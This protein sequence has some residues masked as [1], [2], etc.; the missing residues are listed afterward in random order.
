M[1]TLLSVLW[2]H[3]RLH[4]RLALLLAL[5]LVA[6]AAVWVAEPLYSGYAVDELLKIATGEPV[7]FARLFGWWAVLLVVIS[8]VE[9]LRKYVEWKFSMMLELEGLERSYAHAMRLNMHFHTT[10]RS[11]ETM[12]II[13]DGAENASQLA[14]NMIDLLPSFLAGGTFLIIGAMIEWRLAL[15]LLVM[16]A[17][18]VLIMVGGTMRTAKL[19]DKINWL[20]TLPS[21]RAMDAFANVTSVKSGSQEER[22]L[23]YMHNLHTDLLRKQLKIN[24]LWAILEGFHFFIITRVLLIIIS[25]LLLVRGEITLGELYFFQASFFRVLTPFEMLAGI[26]PQWNK[27]VGKVRMAEKVLTLMPEPGMRS[28]GIVPGKMEGKIEFR[29]VSFSY[30]AQ[31]QTEDIRPVDEISHAPESEPEIP[32]ERDAPLH[33]KARPDEPT[34]EDQKPVDTLQ[35]ITLTIRSGEHI[36]LVGESGAGKSTIAMLLNRFYDVTDGAILIDGKD[37]RE[38]DV[39]WWRS[40]IGLVL[41]EN[42]MFN[43]TVLEN[44]RYARPTAT[45]GEVLQAAQ[46]ASADGFIAALPKGMLTEIGERGVKLSGGQRQRIAIARAILKQ[47]TIVILDEATSAL[48]SITERE[49]QQGIAELIAKRTAIIIAHRLS[50]VRSVDRIAVLEKGKLIAVAPHEELLRTCPIY[51][52]MVE[53]QS[54]GMLC[55]ETGA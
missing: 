13:G 41:Q 7:D 14:R 48:D 22:E 40:Q 47:P 20:W 32:V 34:E 49:V 38:L 50:T 10:Q 27:T 35:N 26:L 52:K 55:E 24:R 33:D 1:R 19:Q 4:P 44:I 45:E 37:L 31:E 18:V 16:V 11:G 6:T 54:G 12:K 15:A 3:C 46:R 43:D 23:G 36:A 39:R 8:I 2:R 42:L 28:T 21:G 29:N 9:G 30:L 17:L 25:M 51:R 53:L 5:L